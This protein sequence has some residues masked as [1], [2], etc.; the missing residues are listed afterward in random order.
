MFSGSLNLRRGTNTVVPFA[1]A[2]FSFAKITNEN[3]FRASPAFQCT[4]CLFLLL[5]ISSEMKICARE[6]SIWVIALSCSVLSFFCFHG[7]QK[8]SPAKESWNEFYF[9][10][11]ISS[12]DFLVDARRGFHKCNVFYSCIR[13]IFLC[14]LL[15]S[16]LCNDG[17]KE[18]SISPP[19]PLLSRGEKEVCIVWSFWKIR[20]SNDEMQLSSSPLH[21]GWQW[22]SAEET[23]NESFCGWEYI[24]SCLGEREDHNRWH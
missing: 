3:T 14:F 22:F 1:C 23:G 6:Q 11:F 15:S 12:L 8:R 21:H 24:Q 10:F 4:Y 16:Q 17:K 5:S 18:L 19:N 2:S 7:T 13:M 9:H 20:T